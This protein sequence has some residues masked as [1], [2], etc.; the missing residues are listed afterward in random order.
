M[1]FDQKFFLEIYSK[2]I[3]MN[4]CKSLM[5]RIWINTEFRIMKNK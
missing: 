1:P 2:E 3:I 4:M 5:T